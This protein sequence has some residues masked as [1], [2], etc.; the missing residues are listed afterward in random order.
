MV[1]L[2][3]RRLARGES[4]SERFLAAPEGEAASHSPG[5]TVARCIG[6]A[7]PWRHRSQVKRH[8]HPLWDIASATNALTSGSTDI[9]LSGPTPVIE[10][11]VFCVPAV[12]LSH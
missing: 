4:T 11:Q 1:V 5:G 6:K 2:Q 12:L 9:D 3:L 8:R 7:S 10:D